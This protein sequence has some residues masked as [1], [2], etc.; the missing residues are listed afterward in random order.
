[1]S[2]LRPETAHKPIQP[3]L[4]G[5]RALDFSDQLRMNDDRAGTF[6]GR[7]FCS[8]SSHSFRPWDDWNRRQ[9]YE[10]TRC[11]LRGCGCAR[12]CVV[13][14]LQLRRRSVT[15]AQRALVLPEPENGLLFV[16]D[17]TWISSAF[18]CRCS[19][20]LVGQ[21]NGEQRRNGRASAVPLSIG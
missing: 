13:D 6:A 18:F 20:P 19:W 16:G 8:G 10:S 7:C 11:D 12:C 5:N 21:R 17:C 4:T 3:P 2:N 14:T 9:S 1:M 15:N